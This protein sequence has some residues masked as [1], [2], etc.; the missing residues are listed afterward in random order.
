MKNLKITVA[1]VGAIGGLLAAML[2]RKYEDSITLVAR[3]NHAMALRE[4]GLT[5][6]SDFYGDSTMR[7][8]AVAER[9]EDIPVQDLVLIC[10]KNY[11]L[12]ELCEQIRPCIGAETIVMPVM[13]GVEPGD[14]IREKFPEAV[15]IDS[16]IYTITA[17]DSE[18]SAK[19]SGPYTHMFIGS[20]LRDER[21][22]EAS[23]K[24]YEL[25]KEVGF[26]ARYTDDI[27][28][29][30]WQKFILNCGFNVITARY[31][32]N[33][34]GVRGNSEW[35]KDFHDLMHEAEAVGLREGVNIPEGTAENKFNYCMDNQNDEA[36]SSLKRDVEAKRQAE[37]DAFLGA[38]IR[39]AEKYGIEVP[40]SRRYYNELSE[41][42]EAYM[43]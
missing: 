36:T 37:L 15:C 29:E 20:K 31:H 23:K 2:G 9:G 3:G 7:P 28:S 33:T 17:K 38:V 34:G 42:I 19:Q 21:H 11:S 6:K 13:N 22:V 8:A 24:V 43:V 30:I 5:L 4:K 10:C 35:T 26:D 41:M 39:K 40:C 32:T 16:L 1:G 18:H 27:M 12:D 14:R 25:F